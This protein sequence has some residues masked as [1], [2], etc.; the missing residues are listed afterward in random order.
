MPFKNCNALTTI[1]FVDPSN[2]YRTTDENDCYS[3]L[4]GEKVNITNELSNFID[5]NAEYYWFK[6][7]DINI[8]DPDWL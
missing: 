6:S 4:G 2:W 7:G 3:K 1:T 8:E 5:Y